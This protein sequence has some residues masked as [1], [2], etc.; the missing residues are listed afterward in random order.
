MIGS[1]SIMIWIKISP[2][3]CGIDLRSFVEWQKIKIMSLRME[4][5]RSW[6]ILQCHREKKTIRT[7]KQIEVTSSK[8]FSF[9]DGSFFRIA[10]TN[11]Q[12][13]FDFLKCLKSD[14]F[15]SKLLVWS[16]VSLSHSTHTLTQMHFFRGFFSTVVKNKQRT[17][18]HAGTMVSQWISL[19]ITVE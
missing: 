14:S 2:I 4:R 7:S 13:E 3:Y 17:H 11:K 8:Y 16:V 10:L 18:T 6:H 12:N 5:R 9:S 1:L 19:I 15:I